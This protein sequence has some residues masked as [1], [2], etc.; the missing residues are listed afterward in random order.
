M[1]TISSTLTKLPPTTSSAPITTI[2]ATTIR[3]KDLCVGRQNGLYRHP[4]EC[5]TYIQCYNNR[6]F[7]R[8]CAAGTLFDE[9][10]SNC[11]FAH[12]VKCNTASQATTSTPSETSKETSI[13][14]TVTYSST[15]TSTDTSK[16][17]SASATTKPST[18]KPKGRCDNTRCALPSCSCYGAATPMNIAADQTPK[19]IMFTMDDNINLRN[20]QFYAALLDGK[21]NPNGCNV[22]ATY[23]VSG[24]YNDYKLT[25]KL[26]DKGHEI[27][28]HTLTHKTP[29]SIWKRA[30]KEFLV[31]EIIGMKKKLESHGIQNITGYRQP[32]LQTAGDT[33]FS[34]LKEYGFTYDSSLPSPVGQYVW[35]FTFDYNPY[36]GSTTATCLISPCP[37]LP[38]NGLWEVPMLSQ[39]DDSSSCSMFDACHR[40][41]STVNEVYM[42][43]KKNFD[44]HFS[45]TSAPFPMFGHA[46]WVMHYT[47]QYREEGLIK[48]LKEMFSRD[49]VYFVSAS[50]VIDWMKNPK[51]LN[52]LNNKTGPFSCPL[53]Q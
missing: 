25:K 53:S 19:M 27:A 23:F 5:S 41:K 6:A 18:M 35:P 51:E 4:K 13:L 20:F 14:T 34:V 12:A 42:F 30:S 47:W 31:E 10:I 21:L 11:N 16:E 39:V 48:F 49:D 40:Y 22:T 7:L 15:S 9:N 29:N 32:F 28:V 44:R 52:M 50:Q 46:S 24:D 36:D 43:F 1:T 3:I 2:T 38:Y 8:P 45:K 17:S 37:T 26:F 33:L